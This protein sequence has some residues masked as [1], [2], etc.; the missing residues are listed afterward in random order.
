MSSASHGRRCPTCLRY[1]PKYPL[2][3]AS[4]LLQDSDLLI[5]LQ[6]NRLSLK[7]RYF[8]SCSNRCLWKRASMLKTAVWLLRVERLVSI[9]VLY[10]AHLKM[11]K[12]G[13]SPRLSS[14][15]VGIAFLVRCPGLKRQ[16]LPSTL[17]WTI[18]TRSLR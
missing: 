17:C 12:S 1:A 5:F 16:A 13:T 8:I 11:L 10:P 2:F 14:L 9:S 18:W 3:G 7:K 15:R 6:K 4:W